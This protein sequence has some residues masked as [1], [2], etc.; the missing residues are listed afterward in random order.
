MKF[1]GE[2]SSL[3]F[4]IRL[5]NVVDQQPSLRYSERKPKNF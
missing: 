2:K 1:E 4:S 5:G 3:A